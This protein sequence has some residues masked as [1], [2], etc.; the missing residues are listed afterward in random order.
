[1]ATLT[2]LYEIEGGAAVMEKLIAAEAAYHDFFRLLHSHSQITEAARDKL[3]IVRANPV[4]TPLSSDPA[5]GPTHVSRADMLTH[6]ILAHVERSEAA[7]REASTALPAL[8]GRRF[9]RKGVGKIALPTYTELKKALE[10]SE[11]GLRTP[12]IRP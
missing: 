11:D 8:L 4:H 2:F 7:F 1:M 12:P 9:G 3:S 10:L 6:A 5:A